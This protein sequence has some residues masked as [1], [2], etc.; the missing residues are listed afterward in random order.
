M[1]WGIPKFIKL[2]KYKVPAY[3]LV[4]GGISVAAAVYLALKE[5][6]VARVMFQVQPQPLSPDRPSILTGRFEDEKGQP[7][8]VKMGRFL[9][10]NGQGQPVRG[11]LIGPNTS[12]FRTTIN[13]AGLPMG[14][15]HIV[16][17]E[18]LVS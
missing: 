5:E 9:V 16:V 10:L 11:G 3:A 1:A 15:Y 4:A 2:G 17:S 6:K 7:V 14:P 13:M 18:D 8:K 12:E